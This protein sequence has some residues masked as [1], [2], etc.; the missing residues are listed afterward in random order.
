MRIFMALFCGLILAGSVYSQGLPN[1]VA[2]AY[3]AYEAA[4]DAEDWTEAAL[5]AELAWRGAESGNVDAATVT[6]LAANFGEVAMIAGNNIGAAEAYERAIDLAEASGSTN[7]EQGTNFVHAARARRAFGDHSIAIDHAMRAIELFETLPEGETRYSGLYQSNLIGAY[8]ADALERYRRSGAFAEAGMEALAYFGPVSN[9]NVAQLAFLAALQANRQRNRSDAL[10]YILTSRII[11]GA[12]EMDGEFRDAS[13]NLQNNVMGATDPQY[14]D[15]IYDRLR[16]SGYVPQRC[17]FVNTC[18]AEPTET[19]GNPDHIPLLRAPP[20]YPVEAADRGLNGWVD[21]RYRV[22]ADGRVAD[23]EVLASTSS[24]FERA[25]M[26][27]V[28]YWRFWPAQENGVD[29][30]Q[31]D[32]ETRIEFMMAD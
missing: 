14:F 27:A 11:S 1:D 4:V 10:Y 25:A 21:L 6:V 3:R 16:A 29:V 17:Y 22:T 15:A 13:R 30:P 2:T 20:A 9:P 26:S 19:D 18:P 7:E 28:R 24:L 32:V 5:Q 12:F 8:S 31:D 23:V